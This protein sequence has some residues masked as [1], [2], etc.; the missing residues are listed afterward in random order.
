M[1]SHQ[2]CSLRHMSSDACNLMLGGV[3]VEMQEVPFQRVSLLTKKWLVRGSY[4]QV[5][6]NVA[7]QWG[8]WGR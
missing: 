7:F 8:M 2:G 3:I 1:S 6:K 5:V 4:H